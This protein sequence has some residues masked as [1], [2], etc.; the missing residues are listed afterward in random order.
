MLLNIPSALFLVLT[1]G[2]VAS[3][4]APGSQCANPPTFVQCINNW[5]AGGTETVCNTYNTTSYEYYKC[6]CL[7]L[8]NHAYCFAA[9]CPSDPTLVRLNS[10]AAEACRNAGNLAPNITVTTFTTATATPTFS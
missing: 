9:F 1:A 4:P 6:E 10:D 5:L 2:L 7:Q 3:S 8:S